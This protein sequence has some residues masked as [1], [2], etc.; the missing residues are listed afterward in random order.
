M[1][2]PLSDDQRPALDALRASLAED[3]ERQRFDALIALL[4]LPRSAD[5][6]RLIEVTAARI[7]AQHG[8]DHAARLAPPTPHSPLE[9][10]IASSLDRW[11]DRGVRDEG[12]DR[13]VTLLD[14]PS[15]AGRDDRITTT[16]ATVQGAV[17]DQ[18]QRLRLDPVADALVAPARF[19]LS[20]LGAIA[21]VL[22]IIASIALPSLSNLRANT[23]AKQST[24]NLQQAGFASGLF[25]SDHDTR[26]PHDVRRDDFMLE[27]KS[28]W[29]VGDPRQS[30][31][32]NL[33]ALIAQNYVNPDVL[34]APGNPHAPSSKGAATRR[35][36][37]DFDQ[38]SYSY[39]LFAGPM[40]P[41]MIGL[42][43]SVLISDRSPVIR[44]I[45]ENGEI[46]PNANSDNHRGRGQH[47]A[48]GD[49]SVAFLATPTLSNGDNLWLPRSAER[50]GRLDL[51]R[52]VLPEGPDDQFVGP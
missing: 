41:S 36:W 24:A 1:S 18:S 51:S 49:G 47:V 16:L 39:R 29:M 30:H 5:A 28:W 48:F 4:S 46:D 44:Q 45:L 32:A 8:P 40:P 2:S 42:Q 19:R 20:D 6:S 13:L 11:V 17:D 7:G 3:A 38:V 33:Y 25:A 34:N 14:L 43:R 52:V 12:I 35:D 31:S 22:V 10:A 9:P 26:I 21:A 27:G 23:W 37:S 50:S 15:D